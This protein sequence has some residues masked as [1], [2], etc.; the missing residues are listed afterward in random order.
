[1]NK[2]KWTFL[3]T[4]LV[5]IGVTAS[6]LINMKSHQRLG[7]PG[8]RTS[9]IPGSK[10]LDVLM[11]TNVLDYTAELQP[12]DKGLLDGLPQ[13]TSFGRCKYTAPDKSQL[14]M[15]IVLMGT[16]RTSIH[17]PQFCLT[18]TGWNIEDARS[19]S[20]SIRVETPHP[21]DLN[22][23]KLIASRDVQFKGQSAPSKVDLIYVYWFV[24]DR[25]L[26][27]SHWERMRRMSTH[28]LTTGELQRWAY[29]S[30]FAIC[31][32]KDEAKTY[33]QLKKF[34][35]A[36]VPQ[37]QLAVGERATPQNSPQAALH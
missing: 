3:I 22:V 36:S 17:K 20:D 24:A 27:E 21:Y 11:P 33:E 34:I 25:Q 6:L 7:K 28:L 37:F 8:V 29:V 4:A 30:Y 10:R 16:D 23:M 14:L 2:Q 19:V 9:E 15:N 26:T 31:L 1:M 18:G 35:A 12:T 13:D 32:P 5:L